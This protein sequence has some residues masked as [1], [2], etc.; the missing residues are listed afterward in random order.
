M[1]LDKENKRVSRRTFIRTAAM[2]SG[3]LA[4][5]ASAPATRAAAPTAPAP[6]RGG[7]LRAAFVGEAPSLDVHWVAA[8]LTLQI[9]LNAVEC[10]F[11]FDDKAS[12]MPEL[13]ESYEGSKDA[14]THTI[15]LRKGVQFHNGKEMTADDVEASLLRWGKMA[16]VG[17]DLFSR[18]EKLEKPDK[19]TLVFKLKTPYAILDTALCSLRGQCAAI[20]PKEVVEAATEKNQITQPM[21]TG[22]YK[23]VEHQKDRFVRLVRND[24]YVSASDKIIG[25][26]GKK[27]AYL[28]ELRLMPVPDQSV[29]LAGVQSGDYDFAEG[30]NTDQY[31]GLKDSK[32]VKTGLTAFDT[33]PIHFLNMKSP[34]MQDRK[35]RQAML[36]CIDPETILK[37]SRG[38]SDFYRLDGSLMVKDSAWYSQAGR[39]NYNQKNPARA[40]Q[41]LQESK[42]KGETLRY[43]TNKEY[44]TMYQESL[45]V[46]QAMQAV[47]INAKLE[48]QDWA[49]QRA[50]ML[51]P[52]DWE[53]FSTMLPFRQDPTLALWMDPTYPGWFITGKAGNKSDDLRDKLFTTMGQKERFAIYEDF[54][55]LYYE[56]V[57]ALKIGD[58]RNLVLAS[59]KLYGFNVFPNAFFWNAYLAK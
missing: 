55:R 41:L 59:P 5:A 15:K 30:I 32:Q 24:K 6:V 1:S 45:V 16:G 46:S 4:L 58:V 53:I 38:S 42:Y 28:D 56:E 8:S 13:A 19:Y 57:P 29:R 18:V 50:R 26:G 2:A 27:N 51:K 54:Q 7:T 3:G 43:L 33:T 36:A 12:P 37:A 44:P 9:S 31:A 35:L 34:I 25:L 10:L 14:M 11:T 40:K 47:G 52:D 39:E 49:T 23:F 20:Y 22:P 17:K 21:G 48:V